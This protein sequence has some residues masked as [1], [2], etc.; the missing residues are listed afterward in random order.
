[1]KLSVRCA[2]PSCGHP[3]NPLDANDGYL[4]CANCGDI[5]KIGVS[6]NVPHET[7]T[8]ERTPKDYRF[9]QRYQRKLDK[10]RE[11]RVDVG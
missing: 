11:L 6:F 7:R 4:D 5:W 8:H 1:M 3:A 2:C 9:T 10:I